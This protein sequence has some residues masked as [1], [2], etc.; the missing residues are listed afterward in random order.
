MT[1]S[2]IQKLMI[3]IAGAAVCC[4][5]VAGFARWNEPK[6][7]LESQEQCASSMKTVALA[8]L[9]YC[10]ATGSFPSGTVANPDLR[11]ADRLSLYVQVGPYLDF[12]GLYSAID[13]A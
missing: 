9:G 1:R 6:H 7:T 11:P 3:I 5:V 10:N 2:S 4:A 13:Q 8:L 12:P